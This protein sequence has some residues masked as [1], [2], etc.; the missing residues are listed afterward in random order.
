MEKWN[1]IQ[2]FYSSDC[3]VHSSNAH[4]P[5]PRQGSVFDDGFVEGHS[6]LATELF[7]ATMA[8]LKVL[9]LSENTLRHDQ[10]RIGCKAKII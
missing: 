5:E 8:K 3:T 4:L 10:A 6:L 2:R 7:H 1:Q 9:H